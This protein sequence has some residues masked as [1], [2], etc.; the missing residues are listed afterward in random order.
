MTNVPFI[1]EVTTVGVCVWLELATNIVLEVR[2]L[3][4]AENFV[5]RSLSLFGVENSKLEVDRS[6]PEKTKQ[7]RTL[8][9]T[10]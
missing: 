1:L 8:T 6:L 5:I 9:F 2:K 10:G 7:N 4:I 3:T